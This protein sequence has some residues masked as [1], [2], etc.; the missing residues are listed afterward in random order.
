MQRTR[1]LGRKLF[2][3]SGESGKKGSGKSQQVD[4]SQVVTKFTLITPDSP[5]ELPLIPKV[6]AWFFQTSDVCYDI[7]RNAIN[8]TKIPSI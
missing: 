5:K 4:G 8:I 3:S 6:Y 2:D 7:K 1:K